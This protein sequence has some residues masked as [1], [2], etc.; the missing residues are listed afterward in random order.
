LDVAFDM[1]DFIKTLHNTASKNGGMNGGVKGAFPVYGSYSM[2]KYPN[3]AA[4]FFADAL[5]LKI[6]LMRDD[7]RT[8]PRRVQI[9][10]QEEPAFS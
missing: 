7:P 10:E 4:K 8:Q 9:V 5:M 6:T 3:W 2:L 1:L